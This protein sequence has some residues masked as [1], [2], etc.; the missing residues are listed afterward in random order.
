MKFRGLGKV[1][2]IAFVANEI[3]TTAFVHVAQRLGLDPQ[4]PFVTVF[5]C[6]TCG[7]VTFWLQ[8]D[9]RRAFG[10]ARANGYVRKAGDAGKAGLQVAADCPK[11]WLVMLHIELN[12]AVAIL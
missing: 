8:S 10:A 5:S 9:A 6:V 3:L 2:F 7:L 4:D 11:R 12:P 1:V